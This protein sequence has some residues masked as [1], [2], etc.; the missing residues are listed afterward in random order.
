LIALS[1]VGLAAQISPDGS[2]LLSSDRPEEREAGARS[3]TAQVP[4]TTESKTALI[5]LLAR[6][7]GL[8]KPEFPKLPAPSAVG[9][10]SAAA[11]EEGYAEYIGWLTGEVMKI[12]D[13]EPDRSDV[14]YALLG[15]VP[16]EGASEYG[17]WLGTHGDKAL[18]YLMAYARDH[19]TDDLDLQNRFGALASLAQ[20]VAFER[21]PDIAHHLS[22][23]DVQTAVKVIQDA[24][25]DRDHNVRARALLGLEIIGDPGDLPLVDHVALTDPYALRDGGDSGAEVQFP[26]R[27]LARRVANDIR[28]KL[29]DKG[30][31]H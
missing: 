2:S 29:A 4:L 27:D 16:G 10:E 28:A 26:V 13:A 30:S 20:I 8:I 1:A 31:A 7:K 19:R 21:R 5:R 17:K 22:E 25:E 9:N 6:E 3:L 14:W 15:A 23:A 12:A 11:I 18:P 24:I